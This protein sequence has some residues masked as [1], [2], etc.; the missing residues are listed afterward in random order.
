MSDNM[1]WRYGETNPVMAAVDSAQVIE[2]GDLLFLNTDDARPASQQADQG[3]EDLNQQLFA[4][5]FLGVAMQ[6]SRGPNSLPG[7]SDG[8]TTPIRVATTGVFEFDVLAGECFELGNLIGPSYCDKRGL[9]D[10]LQ[11][12]Q[13]TKVGDGRYAIG[14]AAKREPKPVTEVLIDIRSAVMGPW[15]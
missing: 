2:I 10:V 13:V 8:A 15:K 12:Q 1:R 5:N 3:T 14:R 11:N 4:L 9:T 7:V 6:R